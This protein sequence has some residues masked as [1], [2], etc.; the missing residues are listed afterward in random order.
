MTW[1]TSRCPEGI[2]MIKTI[3]RA[4]DRDPAALRFLRVPP[5][6][7]TSVGGPDVRCSLR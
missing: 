2:P 6:L 7:L 5:P 1:I 3:G 4:A